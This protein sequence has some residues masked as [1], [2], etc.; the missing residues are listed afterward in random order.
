MQIYNIRNDLLRAAGN[1]EQPKDSVHRIL[2]AQVPNLSISVLEHIEQYLV[3][4]ASGAPQGAIGIRKSAGVAVP[5]GD[6]GAGVPDTTGG[7]AAAV[8]NGEGDMREQ[9]A[10]EAEA[11]AADVPC[12]TWASSCFW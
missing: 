11:A 2:D 1:R 12:T 7:T 10:V 6:T 4:G 9:G 3:A 5:V 8:R